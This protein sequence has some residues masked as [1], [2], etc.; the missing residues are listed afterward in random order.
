MKIHLHAPCWND[1]PMIPYFLRHYEGNA[2]Q[3]R[4]RLLAFGYE[5][6]EV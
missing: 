2:D 6:P 5:L 1:E 4:A 3:I